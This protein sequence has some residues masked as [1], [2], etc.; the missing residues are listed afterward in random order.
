MT[1]VKRQVTKRKSPTSNLI[2]AGLTGDI[3][4]FKNG[5]NIRIVLYVL[6]IFTGALMMLIASTY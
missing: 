1:E 6:G 2:N 4:M 5:D 3:E